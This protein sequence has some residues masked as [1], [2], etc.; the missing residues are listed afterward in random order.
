[1]KRRSLE[2]AVEIV[3]AMFAESMKPTEMPEGYGA[4]IGAEVGACVDALAKAIDTT[5]GEE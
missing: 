3:K 5:E 2:Y 4:K 1:M